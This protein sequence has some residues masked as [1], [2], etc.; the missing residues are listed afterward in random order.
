MHSCNL[1][2]SGAA[3]RGLEIT[4]YTDLGTSLPLLSEP[5]VGLALLVKSCLEECF[6][7]P[8]S[9]ADYEVWSPHAADPSADLEKAWEI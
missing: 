9:R 4:E 6:R 8:D 3:N 2:L 1:L 7:A 5:D